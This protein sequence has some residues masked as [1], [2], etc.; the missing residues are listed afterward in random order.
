M[1]MASVFKRGG[2]TNRPGYYYVSWQDHTGRRRSKCARTTDKATAERIGAKLETEAAQR[3]EG[4]IDPQLEGFAREAKRPL[5]EL[6][7]EY[8]AKLVANGRVERY[9]SEAVGYVERIA[10]AE[11]IDTAVG[12]TSER[13]AHYAAGLTDNGKSA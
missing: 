7:T 13:V 3:R 4:L 11:V 5:A 10:E 9:I 1:T 2:K 8:K 12:F 6:I